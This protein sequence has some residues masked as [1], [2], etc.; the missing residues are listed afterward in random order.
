VIDIPLI[1]NCIVVT[2]GEEMQK[3]SKQLRFEEVQW[4]KLSFRNVV[5]I[6]NL[7]GL[8]QLAKLQLDNNHIRKI[9]NLDHLLN[10]TW[11][12]LSFNQIEKIE[13]LDTLTKIT[14]LCLT[15][16][17]IAK[18]ENIS[19]LVEIEI[20]SC[21][22][23]LIAETE[24]L[25]QLRRF[26]KLRVVNFQNNPVDKDPEYQPVLLAF[27]THLKYLDFRLIDDAKVQSAKEQYFSELQQL[28]FS[29]GEEDKVKKKKQ[30]IDERNARH[31]RANMPGVEMMLVNMLAEDME[32]EKLKLFQDFEEALDDFK[33]DFGELWDKFEKDMLV[34][35][36]RKEEEKAKFE[37]MYYGAIE[38]V[39]QSSKGL[40]S[41]YKLL[42][43]KTKQK[44]ESS[45]FVNR[46]VDLVSR[47]KKDL[48]KEL[49]VRTEELKEK[50]LEL[51]MF[52]IEQYEDLIGQFEEKYG[53]I[54]S[55]TLDCTRMFF[56]KMR[57]MQNTYFEK[58]K[59]KA[60]ELLDKHA[61]GE[62][63]NLRDEATQVLADKDAF[64]TGVVT[65]SHEFR[66]S[67]IDAKDE[68]LTKRETE[69]YDRLSEEKQSTE[70][71]RSRTRT[72]EVMSMIRFFEREIDEMAAMV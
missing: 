20:F 8:H 7:M 53:G 39:D 42:K 44:L 32:G 5:R 27:L 57:E 14:D 25:Q 13:G 40:V 43:K 59:D 11:L 68:E 67:K 41:D 1:E 52:Q 17:K 66:L 6:E 33:D 21:A 70:K 46:A 48:I 30:E 22:N 63:M 38:A 31:A 29:E 64:M 72:D 55:S 12:D 69:N 54:R 49:R 36:E 71:E 10:L 15:H 4:L 26:E 24:Q 37:K 19:T 62:V 45:E 28:T 18:I 9:E 47:D 58:V 50:L 34:L 16:N 23:N 56:E 3:Q 61:A 60:K 35:Y 2:G 51:E 65:G